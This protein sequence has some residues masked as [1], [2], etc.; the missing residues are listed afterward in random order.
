[1]FE[2]NRGPRSQELA[3]REFARDVETF[4]AGTTTGQADDETVTPLIERAW[5]LSH[6]HGEG[7]LRW[8][9]SGMPMT[10]EQIAGHAEAAAR[11]LRTAGWNPSVRAGRGIRDALIHAETN[12]PDRRFGYDTR[13]AVGDI[14]GLLIRALTG[15]P[16]AYYETWDDHPDRTVEEVLTLLAAAAA[17]ARRYG[18]DGRTSRRTAA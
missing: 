8:G 16:H 1:M 6:P 15:A 7:W 4:V 10:G 17:F 18:T 5:A 11:A 12:D 9:S 2:L 13:L 14:L 3:E